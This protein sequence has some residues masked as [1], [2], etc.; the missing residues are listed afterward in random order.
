MPID[1]PDDCHVLPDGSAIGKATARPCR[2]GR[3]LFLVVAPGDGRLCVQC[4]DCCKAR[5]NSTV[6]GTLDISTWKWTPRRG[7]RHGE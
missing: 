5:A 7:G 3:T 2:C 1:W 4:P 6:L